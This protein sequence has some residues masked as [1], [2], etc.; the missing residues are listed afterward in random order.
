[1]GTRKLF[2]HTSSVFHGSLHRVLLHDNAHQ[3][4]PQKFDFFLYLGVH[5]QVTPINYAPSIFLSALGKRG[6]PPGYACVSEP[7]TH[8]LSRRY[9]H[10][11][12]AKHTVTGDAGVVVKL[13]A[14]VNAGEDEFDKGEKDVNSS[15]DNEQYSD[16]IRMDMTV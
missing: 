7:H 16:D 10:Q 2:P 3:K 5:L 13:V 9:T 1:M 12:S 8:F 4:F 6:A 14:D 11:R 15:S